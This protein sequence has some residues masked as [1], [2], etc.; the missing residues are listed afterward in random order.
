MCWAEKEYG[1]RKFVASVSPRNA[2]SLALI[3]KAGFC[4]IEKHVDDET[5][6][7]HIYL[8]DKAAIDETAAS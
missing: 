5:G 2:P 4:K 8:R 3:A 7:E 6:V 1:V